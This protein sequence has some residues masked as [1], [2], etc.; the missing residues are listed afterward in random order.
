MKKPFK[1]LRWSF[2]DHNLRTYIQRQRYRPFEERFENKKAVRGLLDKL[3]ENI[4]IKKSEKILT[5]FRHSVWPSRI[6][7]KFDKNI[8][9]ENTKRELETGK[10]RVWLKPHNILKIKCLMR[11]YL[12]MLFAICSLYNNVIAPWLLSKKNLYTL[13]TFNYFNKHYF[14]YYFLKIKIFQHL[15][16]ANIL[17]KAHNSTFIYYFNLSLF[18]KLN[19][20]NVILNFESYKNESDK[21]LNT[22][23]DEGLDPTQLYTLKVKG[24]S[25]THMVIDFYDYIKRKNRTRVLSKIGYKSKRVNDSWNIIEKGNDN[26]ILI[27]NKV[28][29][30]NKKKHLIRHDN[31]YFFFIIYEFTLKL[32]DLCNKLSVNYFNYDFFGK[33]YSIRSLRFLSREPKVKFDYNSKINTLKSPYVSESS[34]NVINKKFNPKYHLLNLKYYSIKIPIELFLL[35]VVYWINHRRYRYNLYIRGDLYFQEYFSKMHYFIRETIGRWGKNKIIKA[36]I[37]HYSLNKG[38]RINIINTVS[39]YVELKWFNNWF[40]FYYCGESYPLLHIIT[41]KNS[42]IKPLFNLLL[43]ESSILNITNKKNNLVDFYNKCYFRSYYLYELYNGYRLFMSQYITKFE[44]L[45]PFAHGM[46]IN[47]EVMTNQMYKVPYDR[48]YLVT[49]LKKKTVL[50]NYFNIL[51]GINYMNLYFLNDFFN[52]NKTNI[53]KNTIKALNIFDKIFAIVIDVLDPYFFRCFSYRYY[54]NKKAKRF[55][56]ECYEYIMYSLLSFSFIS[57]YEEMILPLGKEYYSDDRVIKIDYD[58]PKFNILMHYLYWKINTGN[59]FIINSAH[60]NYILQT[61]IAINF[62]YIQRFK[63][64]AFQINLLLKK[65][66]VSDT[67]KFNYYKIMDVLKSHYLELLWN[68]VEYILL[69]YFLNEKRY[70]KLLLNLK[71]NPYMKFIYSTFIYRHYI[72]NLWL[73]SRYYDDWFYNKKKR[74]FWMYKKFKKHEGAHFYTKT[75]HII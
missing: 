50:I 13:N 12:I 26:D 27:K 62:I 22:T 46:F 23:S 10:F 49:Y 75:G 42:N 74:V 63:D 54:P 51:I 59:T 45:F 57:I 11:L 47:Y 3:R 64:L 24:K 40:S 38:N 66:T 29:L 56:R 39:N 5:F 19:Y 14:N 73:E 18:N 9:I 17:D 16:K 20:F 34:E 1:E 36:P 61:N 7:R 70:T 72:Y 31:I 21:V 41:T 52:F 30:K 44:R 55:K 58:V 60:S 25:P 4:K 2:I 65:F 33:M 68:N 8:L 35:H 28:D 67:Y 53:V 15:I 48:K 71:I 37:M 69:F 6:V 32:H 43:G